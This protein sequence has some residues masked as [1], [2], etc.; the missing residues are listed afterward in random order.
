VISYAIVLGVAFGT[1][2]LLTPLVRRL[3]IRMGAVVAPGE[4]RVHTRPMP[5]LGGTAMYLAFLA[6]MGVAWQL[7]EF[8]EMFASSSEPLGVI[9]AATVIFAVG[10]LDDLREVSAPAKAAGQVFAGS[11]LYLFGV[12]MFFFR[13][14][15]G[16]IVVLSPDIAPLVTVL[17]V[18]GMANAINFIDGLDGLA[19]GVVGIAA[20]SYFLYD[21]RL[22]DIGL[23][24]EDNIS[25]LLA[26][27]VLGVC[28]GFL[29]HNFQPERIM[30]GDAGAMLLGLLMAASTMVV[31][32][33]TADSFSGQTFFFFAPLFI[34]LVI[35]G[36]PILDT[37][38]AILRRASRRA[39]VA[40]ADKE[41]LHHRLMQLGHGQ[42]RSVLIL[43]AWTAI[44]SGFVLYP[45]Y[46][47]EGNAIV[48][49]GILALGVGLYTVLHPQARRGRNGEPAA[50]TASTGAEDASGPSGNGHATARAHEHDP[51]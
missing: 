8:D 27:I 30:M 38:F 34:P 45:A 21:N 48:P 25:P 40:A 29:P 2:I 44:L 20:G 49:F 35:L 47:E 32:G 12:T 11:V 51:D 50:L 10:A 5:T 42:R 7:D 22:V 1:A 18:V 4:R 3:A 16:D 41:H 17:W 39:N 33:R 31:G 24:G 26:V 14:P 15:Y 28:L 19:A 23:I 37:A 13:I 36:V 6:A 43:W 9:V 46:T